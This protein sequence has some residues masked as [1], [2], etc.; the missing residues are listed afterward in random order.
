MKKISY[1][2]CSFYYSVIQAVWLGW[3]NRNS[4]KVL[5][6]SLF[7]QLLG[8]SSSS[9]GL[10]YPEPMKYSPT[11][12]VSSITPVVQVVQLGWTIHRTHKMFS[13]DQYSLYYSVFRAVQL[14]W[15]IH[16]THEM[17]YNLF[18]QRNNSSLI[19]VHLITWYFKQFSLIYPPRTDE[20]LS[21]N[22]IL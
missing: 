2:L 1:N 22:F 14:S 6:W 7:I 20:K 17:F 11:I 12:L 9:L 3:T 15:T 13:Y 21:Y 8:S 18:E 4:W 5:Q 10:N 19:L 16:Q